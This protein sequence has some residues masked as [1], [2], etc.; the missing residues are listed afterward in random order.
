MGTLLR[1]LAPGWAMPGL[2]RARR[3]FVQSQIAG[4]WWSR[5][6]LHQ[7]RRRPP[8]TLNE[9][10]RYRMA[11]DRRAVLTTFADKAAVRDY[12][13]ARAGPDYLT[14]CYAIVTDPAE[15]PWSDLPDRFVIK[16][17]HASGAVI[18]VDDR[19]PRDRAIPDPDPTMLWRTKCR[20]HPERVDQE[21]VMRLARSWLGSSYWRAHGITEWAYRDIP[22]QLIIEELLGDES[23]NAAPRDYK[24]WCF[25][26]IPR[27]LQVDI[28]RFED[29]RRSLH[30]PDWTP[31]DATILYP[32]PPERPARPDSLDRMLEVA[33]ELSVGIDF[34][35]VDLYATD[36]RVV[37]GELTNYPEGGGGAMHP[38]QV[39]SELGAEWDPRCG[40]RR[41]A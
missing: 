7:F 16:P 34:L 18:L 29:H 28:D 40:Q 19:A 25:D 3:R 8:R 37:F 17:T 36:G 32:P 1:R 41:R 22:P 31:L 12:V 27:F 11:A 38:E 15:I 5:R 35:R 30:L 39:L 4:W 21:R 24:F 6:V 20:I 33:R 14:E 13:A 9:K 10:I 23:A 2:R 26:G